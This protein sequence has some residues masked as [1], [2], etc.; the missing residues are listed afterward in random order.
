MKE[1]GARNARRKLDVRELKK[2]MVFTATPEQTYIIVLAVHD[3]PDKNKLERISTDR[4]EPLGGYVYDD[5]A[6]SYCMCCADFLP[7][8]YIPVS[9]EMTI[10]GVGYW[11]TRIPLPE[12]VIRRYLGDAQLADL[13]GFQKLFDKDHEFHFLQ[14]IG[15]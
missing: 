8:G 11:D 12:S 9:F 2:Q 4:G 14:L 15:D 3:N 6:Q 13:D 1:A 5:V 10:K 7:L